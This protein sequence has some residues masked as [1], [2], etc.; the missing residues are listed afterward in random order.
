MWERKLA[1]KVNLLFVGRTMFDDETITLL[2]AILDE[3]CGHVDR[4][5]NATRA[6]VAVKILAAARS[7]LC[8]IDEICEAGREALRTAPVSWR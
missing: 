8:T 2:R 5:Q 7:K 3:V 1:I 4:Y 6:H